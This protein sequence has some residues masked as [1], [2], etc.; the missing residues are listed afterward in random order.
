MWPFKSEDAALNVETIV[1][2]ASKDLVV[3]GGRGGLEMIDNLRLGCEG[4]VLAPDIAPIAA[5]IFDLWKQGSVQQA[6]EIYSA[7]LPEITF[8][9][10]SL[11]HLVTYGKRIFAT[12]AGLTVYD[13]SPCLAPTLFGIQS[14]ERFA[15]QLAQYIG[16]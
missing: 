12:H 7:A 16:Y 4:L 13:R 3:L 10:Q 9:M 6:E 1:S 2:A 11:E 5:K 8:V 14:S 15:Q